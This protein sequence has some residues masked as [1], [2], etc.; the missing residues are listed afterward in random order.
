MRYLQKFVFTLLSLFLVGCGGSD[1]DGGGGTASITL[2]VSQITAS[3][4]QGDIYEVDVT[5][6]YQGEGVL[7]GMPKGVNEV[8][9]WLGADKQSITSNQA[10][11][12]VYLHGNVDTGVYNSALRFVTAYSNGS[13]AY[14]DVPI[15]LT[16][17]EPLF[18]TA[19]A[20]KQNVTLESMI[21]VSDSGP[22]EGNNTYI[23][24]G[25][26]SDWDW[27]DVEV[28]NNQYKAKII[29][30]DLSV[31]EHIG[32]I[33]FLD[34]NYRFRKVKIVYLVT[35]PEFNIDTVNK[36]TINNETIASE[37][38]MTIPVTPTSEGVIWNVIDSSSMIS[39]TQNLNNVDVSL[40]FDLLSQSN[41]IYKQWIE[42]EYQYGDLLFPKTRKIEFDVEIDFTDIQQISPYVLY[43]SDEVTVRVWGNNLMSLTEEDF[44]AFTSTIQSVNYI[45]DNEVEL[46]IKANATEQEINFVIE[47]SL[48]YLRG[49][50]RVVVRHAPV[51]P[52]VSINLPENPASKVIYDS[53]RERFYFRSYSNWTNLLYE[54]SHDNEQ[55]IVEQIVGESPKGL[56]II[57][58]GTQLLTSSVSCSMTKIDLDTKV[59]V[60]A[61]SVTHCGYMD[62]GFIGQYYTGETVVIDT[63]Q[64][65]SI[66]N[67][68]NWELATVNYPNV[69]SPNAILSKN[70]THLIWTDSTGISS[71]RNAYVY[72]VR[73]NKFNE[74]NTNSSYAFYLDSFSISATGERVSF[75]NRIYNREA[76][77]IG[78]VGLNDDVW[79]RT[80]VSLDGTLAAHYDFSERKIDIYDIQS[81]EGAFFTLDLPLVVNEENM[82]IK[83]IQF[84][85]DNRYIFVFSSNLNT[86]KYNMSIYE[87]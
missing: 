76:I 59:T 65:P 74:L 70:G 60:D 12:R 69:Y 77:T 15:E 47:N 68:P 27:L 10:V 14:K 56:A 72:D 26:F 75:Q 43:T 45:S 41:G 53:E 58:N 81:D 4:Y 29:K 9:I 86:E 48:D 6:N 71:P 21:S 66:Y 64:W 5:V 23:T 35:E 57:D 32:Y 49:E 20:G 38:N 63:N 36:L 80:F 39:V 18:F 40:E 25:A 33:E 62:F 42:F 82:F 67:Y 37:L 7:V 8:P 84:S 17:K 3:V 22:V 83:E 19:V 30:T 78:N 11:F 1:D 31:G 2:N 28:V 44:K 73:N 85:E 34:Q 54:I 79:N 61:P 51:F 50:A 13:V 16:V 52:V 24:Y 55:W 87:R 46:N